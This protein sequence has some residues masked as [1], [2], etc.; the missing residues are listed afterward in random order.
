MISNSIASY[1]TLQMPVGREATWKGGDSDWEGKEIVAA[2][3]TFGADRWSK[4]ARYI[5]SFSKRNQSNIKL[6]IFGEEWVRWKGF[7]LNIS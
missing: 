6:Q 7:V 1:I 4:K 5:L 2:G 3:T